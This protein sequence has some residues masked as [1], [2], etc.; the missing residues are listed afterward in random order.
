MATYDQYLIKQK[1]KREKKK[2]FTKRYRIIRCFDIS[3]LNQQTSQ[4]EVSTYVSKRL[5]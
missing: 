2:N 3:V 5:I 4:I 1:K